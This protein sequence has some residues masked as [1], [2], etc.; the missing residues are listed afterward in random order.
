MSV[1][2]VQLV[3]IFVA[4]DA[5]VN[6]HPFALFYQVIADL[7]SNLLTILSCVVVLV[8]TFVLVFEVDGGSYLFFKCVLVFLVL[9]DHNSLFVLEFYVIARLVIDNKV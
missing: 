2:D 7:V 4:I 6:P 8:W 5:L 3:V 1:L 9:D